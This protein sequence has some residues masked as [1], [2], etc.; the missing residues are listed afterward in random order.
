MR[1]SFKLHQFYN[2]LLAVDTLQ[3][4]DCMSKIN[5]IV[6]SLRP[7]QRVVVLSTIE[8]NKGAN[9][10]GILRSSRNEINT[11][12]YKIDLSKNIR[13]QFDVAMNHILNSNSVGIIHKNNIEV[14]WEPH[15]VPFHLLSS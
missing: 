3:L 14:M 4:K 7:D 11:P 15:G 2:G 9:F 13:R 6:R 10:Y 12:A 1:N 5:G 8:S